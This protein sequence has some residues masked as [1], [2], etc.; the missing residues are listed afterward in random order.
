MS[1]HQTNFES[2]LID[3][4]SGSNI[5]TYRHPHCPGWRIILNNPNIPLATNDTG[6]KGYF[7]GDTN[8]QY[9]TDV[10]NSRQKKGPTQSSGSFNVVITVWHTFCKG[11][12]EST[13][14]LEKLIG[15]ELDYY[16]IEEMNDARA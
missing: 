1:S 16:V 4:K 12:E 8:F 13:V 9:V 10:L 11:N 6:I 3:I 2:K 5:K 14:W 7:I 15:D